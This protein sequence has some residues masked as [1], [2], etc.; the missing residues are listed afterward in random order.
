M[1]YLSCYCLYLGVG[2]CSRI[3]FSFGNDL[4]PYSRQMILNMNI[5]IFVSIIQGLDFKVKGQQHGWSTLH[6]ALTKLLNSAATTWKW[7]M[8]ITLLRYEHTGTVMS[9][10]MGEFDSWHCCSWWILQW[11]N[12]WL[13]L[14]ILCNVSGWH[15]RW[16]VSSSSKLVHWTLNSSGGR[17]MNY[18]CL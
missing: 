18:Q 13:W 12:L 2:Q 9:P 8:T 11:K 17:S 1:F 7:N 6:W 5:Y 14:W 4:A 16:S 15:D 3:R 10:R